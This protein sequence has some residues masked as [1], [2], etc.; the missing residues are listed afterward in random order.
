MK[1]GK[2]VAA[3]TFVAMCFATPALAGNWNGAYAGLGVGADHAKT[4]PAQMSGTSGLASVYGGYRH[5]FGRAVLGG[6]VGVSK[7][8]ALGAS[9]MS[10]LYDAKLTAG[11]DLGRTMVY[12]ALG[13]AHAKN[14][15]GIGETMGI[16]IDHAIGAHTTVGLEATHMFFNNGV[17]SNMDLKNNLV[18][19][20]VGYRF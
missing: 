2:M 6:E 16:G 1:Y 9:S 19:A 4:S 13:V 14:I 10:N 11:Y 15:H 12:G 18:Q 3:A 20:K 5:D 17:A 7:T 8:H